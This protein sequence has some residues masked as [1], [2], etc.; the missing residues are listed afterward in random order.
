[1]VQNIGKRMLKL[2]V[3]TFIN[4]WDSFLLI[5]LIFNAEKSAKNKTCLLSKLMISSDRLQLIALMCS[6]S[7][8][9]P[10][11]GISQVKGF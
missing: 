1:M 5:A 10:L 4:I 9:V 11:S 3:Q 8:S 7:K 6:F 2:G